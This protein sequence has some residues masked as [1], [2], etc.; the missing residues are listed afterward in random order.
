MSYYI[1]PKINNT[2]NFNLK[3]VD[4]SNMLTPYISYSLIFYYSELLNQIRHIIRN[5]VD[6]S[7]ILVDDIIKTINPYE[8]I[9]TKVPET[10]YSVSK[11]KS[12]S[13][14][15]YDLLEIIN[16]INVIDKYKENMNCIFFSPNS[17]D[18]NECIEYI[19]DD[20]NYNDIYE[21]YESLNNFNIFKNK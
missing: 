12:R 19:R 5:D 11:L 1:L 6:C 3:T 7:N 21:N 14:V 15:I 10:K 17:K 9:F 2:L 4:S 13:N 18:I 8:Y 20:S 16:T